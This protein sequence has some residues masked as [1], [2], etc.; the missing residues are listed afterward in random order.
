[1]VR[2]FI[3]VFATTVRKEPAVV[4]PMKIVVDEDK[5]RLPCN[6]A[7]PDPGDT[8]YQRVL[9]YGEH[10]GSSS[11]IHQLLRHEAFELEN[12]IDNETITLLEYTVSFIHRRRLHVIPS[13][14]TGQWIGM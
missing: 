10:G 13:L 8:A 9:K 4:E 1:M 11:D 6:R 2:E 3:E 12:L 5:W 7:P 14:T